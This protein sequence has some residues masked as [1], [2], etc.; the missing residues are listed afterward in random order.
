M[1][2]AMEQADQRQAAANPRLAIISEQRSRGTPRSKSQ[3]IEEY[4][5]KLALNAGQPADARVQS[6][7]QALW[8]EGLEDLSY[9]A[10]EAA[11]KK[12]LQT[13]RFWP[14]KVADIRALVDRAQTNATQEEAQ[15]RWNR[16]LDYMRLCYNPDVPPCSA[17]LLARKCDRH[18]PPRVYPRISERTHRAIDAA[19]GLAY[20]SDC[21]RQE[22]LPWARKRFIEAYIRY[23][24]LRQ[25]EYLLPPGEVRNLIANTA[26][27]LLPN[28]C[29]DSYP[30]GRARG[31]EYRDRMSAWVSEVSSTPRQIGRPAGVWKSPEERAKAYAALEEKEDSPAAME[32]MRRQ[33]ARHA[34]MW[35]AVGE[36]PRVSQ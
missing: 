33:K 17:C 7:Y 20:L 6:V 5:I 19:G 3:L 16:V 31:E 22:A 35:P 24:E 30:S 11:F 12:T 1:E 34:E 26:K 32:E 28:S 8:E 23:G 36:A 9:A 14:I 25:D 21:D 15:Q 29:P 18:D 10:L 27:K 2:E 13:C 4:I